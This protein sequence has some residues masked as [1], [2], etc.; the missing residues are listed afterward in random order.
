[1]QRQIV[2]LRKFSLQSFKPLLP[3]T[4]K[5]GTTNPTGAASICQNEENLVAVQQIGRKD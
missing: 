5:A 3:E 4:I 1:L 2:R